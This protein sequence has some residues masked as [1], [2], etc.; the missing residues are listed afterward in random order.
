MNLHRS[1][2]E[3]V[4]VAQRFVAA[5]TALAACC[6]ALS[7]ARVAVAP[8][9]PYHVLFWSEIHAQYLNRSDCSIPSA[10]KCGPCS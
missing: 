4:G 8:L 7:A 1:A 3:R 5:W 6:T 9:H 2:F 10:C